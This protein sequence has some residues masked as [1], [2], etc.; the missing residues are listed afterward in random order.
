MSSSPTA[1]WLLAASSI[2]CAA[3]TTAASAPT[4]AERDAAGLDGTATSPALPSVRGAGSGGSA[5]GPVLPVPVSVVLKVGDAPAGA[6][7]GDTVSALNSPFTDGNGKVG[8]VGS[9]APSSARFV[10]HDT[11]LVFLSTSAPTPLTGGEG[12]MGTSDTGG[13]IYSPSVNGTDGVWSHNGLL[14]VG[15]TQAA[16]FPAGTNSTF[17]SRPT[18]RPDGRAHWV[19]GLNASG[20]TTTQFRTIYTSPDATAA[21]AVPVITEGD[22]VGTQAILTLEFS[23]DF[24]D[25]SAHHIQKMSLDTGSTTNDSAIWVDGAVVARELDSTGAGDAWQAFDNVSINTQGH[26]LFSGDTNGAT[27]TDEFIAYDGVLALREGA[28]VDG[29]VLGTSV[30]TLAINDLNQAVHIWSVAGGEALFYACDASDLAGTSQLLLRTGDTVDVDGNGTA[31][32]TVADFEASFV[33]GPGLDLA[34]DGRVFVELTLTFVTGDAEAIV[35][36]TLPAGCGG[37]AAFCPGDGTGTACPCGNSGTAGNGCANSVNANGA[38]LAATGTPSLAADTL[39]LQGSGMPN[40]SALYFQGTSDLAGGAGT[41]FGDGLRCAGGSIIRLSTKFNAAGASQFPVGG[42]PSVSV[43][44]LVAA[45][46][47][48][49]YQVW[50]RNAA[51]FCTTSTFNLT[52]GL[53]VDWTL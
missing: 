6:P 7:V 24:S 52:N 28:T 13:F 37:I 41:A 8:F 23:Y 34:E 49:T 48:R 36:L 1:S 16:G 19:A 10:W 9:L 33:I 11:G 45:P 40:S 35:A 2:L 46:G 43:R 39:V 51:A 20:G 21:N 15:G 29:V 27:A 17:H 14:A 50:Y 30:N 5:L 44:G 4:D 22:L 42:D 18:M 26:Y 53:R 12:T 47:S 31:D 32:A 3:V 38:N 25:D